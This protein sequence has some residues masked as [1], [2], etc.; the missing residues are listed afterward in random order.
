MHMTVWYIVCVC[1]FCPLY[2]SMLAYKYD[3]STHCCKL[4]SAQWQ[5]GAT[6]KQLDPAHICS[7][8]VCPLFLCRDVHLISR[9]APWEYQGSDRRSGIL[10]KLFV[11]W[12]LTMQANREDG[13]VVE[14]VVRVNS[15]TVGLCG[16]NDWTLVF[17]H[18]HWQCAVW[19]ACHRHAQFY[20]VAKLTCLGTVGLC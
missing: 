1:L 17:C 10:G 5:H 15:W 16:Q 12:I 4:T 2:V 9:G 13:R 8:Y 14:I 18:I 19:T 7:S 3:W 20:Y 11:D 6:E